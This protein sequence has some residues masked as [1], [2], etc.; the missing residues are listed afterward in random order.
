MVFGAFLVLYPRGFRR[1]FGGVMTAA[2]RDALSAVR[3]RGVRI[4]A[5]L[6][7]STVLDVLRSAAIEHLHEMKR[8]VRRTTYRPIER[9]MDSNAG[10]RRNSVDNIV[11]DVRWAMRSL[12]R[13]PSFALV[14][15][16]TIALGIGANTA[17]FGVVKTVLLT[18]LPYRDPAGIAMI[19]SRWSN[20]QKTWVSEGEFHN[21]R[22][23]LKSFEDI[24]LFYTF[25]TN[26][27][28]GEEPERVAMTNVMPNV[29][30]ILGVSPMLG[31]GFT[32]EEAKGNGASVIVLGYEQWQRRYGADPSV[33]GRTMSL[34]GRPYE[35]I[36]VMPPGFRMPLDFATDRPAQAWLPYTLS[37]QPGGP[38][39][40]AGGNHGSYAVGRLRPGATVDGVNAE[41]KG[42]VARLNADGVYP[43][44][45]HFEAFAV[46]APDQV[47]GFLRPALLVLMG[48][49]GFVLL[50]ACA[51]VANLLLARGE[52]RRV[53]IGVRSA[54]GASG[55]RLLRQMFTENLILGLGGGVL[56]MGLGWAGMVAVRTLAPTSLPRIPEARID[57]GVLAFCLL[58]SV[59]TA[60]LFGLVPAMRVLRSDVRSVIDEGG[61]ANT[62][63][64]LRGRAR[65][66]LIAVEVALAVVLAAGA[67]LMLRSFW[68]LV[69]ID[70]GFNARSVLTM[71]LSTPSAF[72]PDDATVTGFYT[73][74]LR[75][76]RALPGV[77][78]AGMVRLLPIDQEMG[79]SCVGV[80][81]YMPPQG[82]CPAAD[83]QA[84][85]DGYFEAIGQ[86][87]LEGRGIEATDVADATQVIVV[88]QAFVRKFFAD[89]TALGKHV[90]FS[91]VANVPQQTVVGVVADVRHNALTGT[92][93]PAFWRPHAQ[94]NV[95]TGFPQRSMTLV[96]RTSQEAHSLIQP[97]RS[98]IRDMDPRLPVASIQT[99]EEVMSRA[100][101]QPR[102]TM[103]LLLA[104][105]AMALVLAVIGIHGVVAFAVASRRQELGIR[106]A[107]GAAPRSVIWLSLRHGMEYA[108]VGV[109]AG[110]A[111]SLV[112]TRLMRNLLYDVTPTDPATYAVV[113]A[114]A[115]LVALGASWF[116]A[117]RAARADPLSSLRSST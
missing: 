89:G 87:V 54:M 82:E 114:L 74:L 66:L 68:H 25:D 11:Q 45:W 108:L 37:V 52:S 71:R 42:V 85:S 34:N 16:L 113:A 7:A 2:F 12:R 4:A 105:G 69:A 76:V 41:L 78:S 35:I 97:V 79:D 104:F 31:R 93:K 62:P 100:L 46:S 95:S 51:N 49:V 30:G 39:P 23:T 111:A 29:F 14:A 32:E 60:I 40:P 21:Y 99:M 9:T 115:L 43:P 53:E 98:V 48:A 73:E 80:E 38:V 6:W 67:G 27:T 58:L 57:A 56:G 65:R 26:I 50:I 19:W 61:R 81:G 109:V 101:A 22:A 72:Y 107:L 15:G 94:W 103:S 55:I 110:T 77:S 3:G 75:R 92:V 17:L 112:A 84:A 20:F 44:T 47:S 83:W 64:A 88:N 90:D 106:M 102:F 36:G 59:G 63:G 5:A 91:F 1:R 8:R 13:H 96:I 33:L 70:P 86:E 116:P 18:P 24:G 10:R 117:R 28:E